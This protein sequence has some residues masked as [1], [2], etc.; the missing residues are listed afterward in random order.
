MLDRRHSESDNDS[1]NDAEKDGLLNSKPLRP[2]K[3]I[4]P[5][6][7]IIAFISQSLLN[8]TLLVACIGLFLWGQSAWK[9]QQTVTDNYSVQEAFGANKQYMTLDHAFDYL[10]SETGNSSIVKLDPSLNKVES[11]SM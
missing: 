2:S 11:V 10:W 7:L 4:S 1:L 8:L 9:L 3:S 5:G 6:L